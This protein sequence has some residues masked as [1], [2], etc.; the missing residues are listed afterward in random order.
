MT[1]TQFKAIRKELDLTK[2]ELAEHIG[3][4]L[5]MVQHYEA[6][7]KDIPDIVIKL[8]KLIKER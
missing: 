8:I 3:R 6:G 5:R 4:T 7:T 2:P 1:P